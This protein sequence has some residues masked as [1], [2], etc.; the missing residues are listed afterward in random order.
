MGLL[1]DISLDSFANAPLVFWIKMYTSNP[2]PLRLSPGRLAN[3]IPTAHSQTPHPRDVYIPPP[4]CLS[5]FPIK[6]YCFSCPKSHQL[7]AHVFPHFLGK[8]KNSTLDVDVVLLHSGLFRNRARTFPCSSLHLLNHCC[9]RHVF[10]SRDLNNDSLLHSSAL[11]KRRNHGHVFAAF[12][13]GKRI[14]TARHVS[15]SRVGK[16]LPS[17]YLGV[18][19]KGTATYTCSSLRFP[20]HPCRCRCHVFCSRDPNSDLLLHFSA[21]QSHLG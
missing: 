7:F 13:K 6:V 18:F 15:C 16:Q 5:F 21:F 8:S 2:S 10:R 19:R 14:S 9:C 4:L 20:N 1:C 11:Y 12:S 17:F 3:T